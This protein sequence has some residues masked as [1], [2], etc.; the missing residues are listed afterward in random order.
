MSRK[1]KAAAALAFSLLT[2]LYLLPTAAWGKPVTAQQAQRAVENWLS[3]D[4]HPLGAGLGQKIKQ[5][6]IFKDKAGN[7]IYFAVSLEPSGLVIVS[8]DDLVEPIIAFLSEGHYDPSPANPLG[9]MVSR[10]VP[11]RVSRVREMEAQAR[12]ERREVTLAGQLKKAHHKWGLL[13]RQT[14]EAPVG[15]LPTVSEIRVAPLVQSKWAQG[16]VGADYCFNYYTPN[17]YVCGCVATAL[18]QLMRYHRHPD[19]GV[20]NEMYSVRVDGITQYLEVRGGDSNGGPYDWYNM[21]LCPDANTTATARQAIGALTYDAGLSV[22]MEYTAINS[23]AFLLGG[24][25]LRNTFHYENAIEGGSYGG[26]TP[27]PYANLLAMMNPNLDTGLPV[28]LSIVGEVG[29]HAIVG[30]GYGYNADTLYHH[31]NMGWLGL[32]DAWYN[33]PDVPTSKA[34]FNVVAGC[35]YN[36]YPIG[37]GEIISG[38]VTASSG[39]PINQATVTAFQDGGATRTATTDSQG[40]YALAKLPSRTAFTLTAAKPGFFFKPRK[41]STGVS[42]FMQS[43]S[44]NLW[45]I[46]FTSMFGGVVPSLEVLLLQ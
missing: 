20:G 14:S 27:I 6:Q 38:R 8:G 1:S 11:A 32:D 35:V 3:L 13:D 45:G 18:A 43:E 28:I 5:A 33:L 42:L 23:G 26:G 39:V 31:L 22:D 40:I 24:S 41:C 29:G 37:D 2:L 25:A 12:L 4:P 34:T 16:N 9:A 30:D 19:V 17:H 21:I 36:I 10:D 46:D 15:G 44:G 7:T